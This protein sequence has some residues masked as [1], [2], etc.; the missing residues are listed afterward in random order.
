MINVEEFTR[1]VIK[2]QEQFGVSK[3]SQRK[4][5][6]I[7]KVVKKLQLQDLTAIIDNFIGNAKFAPTLE[8]FTRAAS[9]FKSHYDESEQVKCSMC[10]SMGIIVC[11]KI[12]G[13]VGEYGFQCSCENGKKYQSLPNW[14]NAYKTKFTKHIIPIGLTDKFYGRN[15]EETTKE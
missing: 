4:N 12:S 9:K 3:F 5:E 10:D 11:R 15:K 7:F 8:D 13:E 1:E 2:L 6:L 14:N